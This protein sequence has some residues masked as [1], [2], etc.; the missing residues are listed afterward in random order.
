MAQKRPGM[1]IA[2]FDIPEELDEEFN[3]WY[4]EEHIPEKVGTVPGFLR[5]RRYQSLEGRPNYVCVYELE[6]VSVVDNPA[7]QSNYKSGSTTTQFMKSKAKTF[8]R[9]VYIEI[10]DFQGIPLPADD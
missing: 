9:N 1:M 4:N 5:A 10:G 2:M 7:Y 8:Y 6:D 3:T